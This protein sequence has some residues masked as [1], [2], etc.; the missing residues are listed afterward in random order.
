VTSIVASRAGGSLCV[1]GAGNANALDLGR[2]A[3]RFDAV[4][5]ADVDAAALARALERQS[6]GTRAK[7]VQH[8][9][10]DLSGLLRVLPA[11][12]TRAPGPVE[13]AS[14]GESAPAAVAASL[15]GPFDVVLSDC[16]LTQIYWTCFRALGTGATLNEVISTALTIHL[17]TLAALTRA[18]GT[19]LLMTDVVTSETVPLVQRFAS[20]GPLDLLRALEAEGALFSG[21]GPTLIA[22]AFERAGLAAAF[23]LPEPLEPWIWRVGRSRTALVY[24]LALVRS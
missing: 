8:A 13:L 4:H 22:D 12:R 6:P 16:L 18:G 7:L 10:V 3:E 15:P 20:E 1:L 2:L 9:H 14:L 17:R 5:L 24:A 21:T 19:A 23:A 11:W